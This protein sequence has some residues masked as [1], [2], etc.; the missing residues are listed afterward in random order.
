MI[1]PSLA[2][3]L[4]LFGQEVF[5]KSAYLF[6][7]FKITHLMWWR[8]LCDVSLDRL[9]RENGWRLRTQHKESSISVFDGDREGSQV[10]IVCLKQMPL[11]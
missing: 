1:A 11:A 4:S 8:Q 9:L 3:A 6:Q 5:E 7:V 2:D 10:Q